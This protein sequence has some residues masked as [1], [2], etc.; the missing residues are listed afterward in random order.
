VIVFTNLPRARELYVLSERA[1]ENASV[2]ERV[3]VAH[4]H[5]RLLEAHARRFHLSRMC[6]REKAWAK[7]TTCL[8]CF[9]Y[10][11]AVP[12]LC[13]AIRARTHLLWRRVLLLQRP[14]ERQ[15]GYVLD[16]ELRADV[17]VAL[18]VIRGELLYR[19]RRP[20]GVGEVRR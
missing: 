19:L 8:S 12:S 10:L 18:H 1:P 16:E 14:F 20:G 15:F 17:A 9:L 5:H 11:Y 7:L 4:H 6:A 2:A 13:P 3:Q